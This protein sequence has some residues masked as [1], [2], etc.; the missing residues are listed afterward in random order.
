[1]MVFVKTAQ[2]RLFRLVPTIFKDKKHSVYVC[3]P[4]FYY[5]KALIIMQIH[6]LA[7]L[8]SV[9]IHMQGEG[10]FRESYILVPRS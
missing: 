2:M 5:S 4:Q 8:K 6:I 9:V 10:P 3:K 1:M 7:Q